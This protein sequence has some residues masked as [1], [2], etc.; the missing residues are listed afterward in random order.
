MARVYGFSSIDKADLYLKVD[1]KSL[2]IIENKNEAYIFSYVC[3]NLMARITNAIL[4]MS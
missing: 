2:K 1:S 4:D 3:V